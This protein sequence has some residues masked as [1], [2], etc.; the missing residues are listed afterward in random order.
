[1]QVAL[2]N[3]HRENNCCDARW[4]TFHSILGADQKARDLWDP[5]CAARSFRNFISPCLR[6]TIDLGNMK[7]ILRVVCV[8]N[9]LS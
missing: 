5:D 1:M 6:I 4:L 3:M 8:V 7:E 2:L 9:I